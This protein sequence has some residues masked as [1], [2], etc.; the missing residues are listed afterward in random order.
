MSRQYLKYLKALISL[1]NIWNNELVLHT[2]A[3]RY[4]SSMCSFNEE[5]LLNV[6]TLAKENQIDLINL[7]LKVPNVTSMRGWRQKIGYFHLFVVGESLLSWKHEGHQTWNTDGRWW[8]VINKTITNTCPLNLVS[9]FK[10]NQGDR[11]TCWQT[12]PHLQ[13]AASFS[14]NNPVLVTSLL[15]SSCWVLRVYHSAPE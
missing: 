4:R 5:S 15:P 7:L 10:M 6:V 3:E 9:L 8:E 12:C 13:A 1:W 11:E 2:F 14:K